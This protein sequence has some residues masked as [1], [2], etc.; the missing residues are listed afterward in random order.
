MSKYV[1]YIYALARQ[2]SL[3]IVSINDGDGYCSE[4]KKV[5]HGSNG[6]GEVGACGG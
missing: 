6:R 3:V 5:Y 1:P 2:D 4:I